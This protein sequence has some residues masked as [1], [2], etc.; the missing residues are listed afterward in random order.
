MIRSKLYTQDT[1]DYF[2]YAE[3]T[4][5]PHNIGGIF[6]FLAYWENWKYSC[7]QDHGNAS[8]CFS[9]IAQAFG[10]ILSKA[11]S[12]LKKILAQILVLRWHLE[13]ED[14]SKQKGIA[15]D[16]NE[17]GELSASMGGL[18]NESEYLKYLEVFIFKFKRVKWKAWKSN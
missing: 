13:T 10:H 16:S 15:D 3:W 2:I 12:L 7:R 17:F 4:K 6:A 11:T 5:V 1:V 14:L 18:L 9:K 8:R